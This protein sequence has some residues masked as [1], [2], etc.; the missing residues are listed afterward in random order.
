MPFVLNPAKGFIVTANNNP[1]PPTYKH[2]YSLGSEYSEGRAERITE[3]IQTQINSGVKFTHLDMLRFQQDEVDVLCRD[4]LPVM[5]ELTDPSAYWDVIA[6]WDCDMR[7]DKVEPHVYHLWLRLFGKALIEDELQDY[8]EALLGNIHYRHFLL[9]MLAQ[10]K[11]DPWSA[12][13][14]DDIRT[15]EKET[16]SQLLASSFEQA[17]AEAGGVP[18][19]QVHAV[20]LSHTFSSMGFLRSLFHRSIEVGGNDFS[21]HSTF[22]SFN[23]DFFTNWGPTFRLVLDLG[24]DDAVYWAVE[25]GQSGVVLSDNYDDM[26]KIF[27]YGPLMVT[28]LD[29]KVDGKRMVISPKGQPAGPKPIEF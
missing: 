24:E 5:L 18:W 10:L 11:S 8:S 12:R 29:D 17:V 13:W 15:E 9:R 28:W 3:L 1:A 20:Q 19:G 27:H 26:T 7:Q 4:A 25:S 16:C 21:P 23:S 22:S 2:F 6:A 14:C